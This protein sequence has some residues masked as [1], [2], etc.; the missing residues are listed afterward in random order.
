MK[1]I[2]T[3]H[4][5]NDRMDRMLMI[6]EHIGWGEPVIEYQDFGRDNICVITSTGV[7]LIKSMDGRRLITAYV[8]TIDQIMI[9]CRRCGYARVPAP[10]Y[11]VAVKNQKRVARWA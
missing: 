7:M 3:K 9:V 2:M 6:A 4:V 11:A 10:L 8:A 1:M 5:V